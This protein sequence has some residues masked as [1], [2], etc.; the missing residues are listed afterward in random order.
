MTHFFY[1]QPGDDVKMSK[2]QAWDDAT[3]FVHPCGMAGALRGRGG[4]MYW[5]YFFYIRKAIVHR[6][7]RGGSGQDRREQ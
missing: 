4:G 7:R 6:P 2:E 3:F 5:E 1:E